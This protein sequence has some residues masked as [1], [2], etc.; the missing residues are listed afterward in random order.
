MAI[1]R[2]LRTEEQI[3]QGVPGARDLR[4][5]S[6]HVERAARLRSGPRNHPIRSIASPWE[7]SHEIRVGQWQD[8][9]PAKFL[10]ALRWTNRRG[11]LF[12]GH[13]DAALL[14]RRGVLR[15]QVRRPRE[16]CRKSG[17]GLVKRRRERLA[18]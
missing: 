6:R 18:Y 9:V 16:A 13:P 2:C 5:G 10:W 14:L 4:T 1:S 3:K 17:Q 11:R 15:A 8:A 7:A 12:A